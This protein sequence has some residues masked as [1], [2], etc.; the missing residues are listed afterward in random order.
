MSKAAEELKET[1]KE[2]MFETDYGWV[3]GFTPIQLENFLKEENEA[4]HHSKVKAITDEGIIEKAK[5]EKH[6]DLGWIDG[7]LA[8]H[9]NLKRQLLNK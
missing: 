2:Q 4:Y 1:F 7:Y 9:N 8:G 3:I 5:K 6:P